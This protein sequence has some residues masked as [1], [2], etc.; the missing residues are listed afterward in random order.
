M[1]L[2]ADE[3]IRRFLFHVLPRGFMRIRHFGFLANARRKKNLALC[4]ELLGVHGEQNPASAS[5]ED[6]KERYERLTG[7][8]LDMCP[9]CH[10]GRLV[11]IEIMLPLRRRYPLPASFD[12]S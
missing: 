6:W 11:T 4:R 10:Q 7:E 1:T 8:S 2:D 5:A 3:F 12:S 9:A